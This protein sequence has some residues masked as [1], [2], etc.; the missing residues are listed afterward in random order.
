VRSH[1]RPAINQFVALA[2][3]ATPRSSGISLVGLCLV[4]IF[5]ASLDCGHLLVPEEAVRDELARREKEAT[6][7]H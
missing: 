2:A 4:D 6:V 7:T 3:F 5:S 1:N